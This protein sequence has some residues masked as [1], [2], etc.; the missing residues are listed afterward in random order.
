MDTS[1]PADN[2][3]SVED[4]P[5]EVWARGRDTQSANRVRGRTPLTGRPSLAKCYIIT[6]SA[7]LNGKI[8]EKI[9]GTWINRN[10][11]TRGL[12]RSY[13]IKLVYIRACKKG[14]GLRAWR[15]ATPWDL[16]R[17]RGLAQ[18]LYAQSGVGP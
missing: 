15:S 16:R 6:R 5:P 12:A 1:L 17:P 18:V 3:E 4:L 10:Y 8:D 9:A 2:P 11:S 7:A 13:R 14:P